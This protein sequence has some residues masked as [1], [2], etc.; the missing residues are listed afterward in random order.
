MSKEGYSFC[1]ITDNKE[2]QKLKREIN[3]IDALKIPNY[4]INIV[5]DDTPPFG[6]TGALRNKVCRMAKF[7]HLIIA[8]DDILFHE[9]FYLGLKNYG[10]D[11]DVMA[12]KILNP[13]G[14]RF[15]D[16]KIYIDGKN[17]LIDYNETNPNISLTSGIY[18]MKQWVFEQV[19]M[20][21]NLGY[22]EGEDV[23]Y[24]ERLKK[25]GMRIKM[26]PYCVVTHDAP[27][28]QAGR[29]VLRMNFRG[30]IS[31]LKYKFLHY[32]NLK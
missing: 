15:Y 4:E 9:D 17:Y 23:D 22:Y 5:S 2:P 29:S 25:A 31:Y 6:R 7:D 16:W 18:I 13:D 32:L 24:S 8:D 10:E 1:I 3:S 14:S 11:Y 26:N 12:C 27:Y 20:D 19:Q 28:K 30:K 21:D